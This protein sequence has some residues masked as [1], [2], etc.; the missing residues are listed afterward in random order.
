MYFF[1]S[2]SGILNKNSHHPDGICNSKRE[3]SRKDHDDGV[4][5]SR[6]YKESCQRAGQGNAGYNQHG[7]N[8]IAFVNELFLQ[9]YALICMKDNAEDDKDYGSNDG[10]DAACGG[11]NEAECAALA[12]GGKLDQNEACRC[13]DAVEE[14]VASEDVVDEVSAVSLDFEKFNYCL[15]GHEDC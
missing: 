6:R 14:E 8:M 1:N 5:R 10:Q 4:D 7:V 3:V 12:D 2:R 15:K 11:E 13:G 9:E